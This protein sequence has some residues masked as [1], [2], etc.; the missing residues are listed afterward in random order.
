MFDDKDFEAHTGVEVEDGEA[1]TD[2][3]PS[4]TLPSDDGAASKQSD[5]DAK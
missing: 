2:A 5:P 4:E 1:E 3:S